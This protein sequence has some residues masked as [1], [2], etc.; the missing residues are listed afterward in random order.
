AA[1]GPAESVDWQTDVDQSRSYY[2]GQ[3]VTHSIFGS[4]VV[5][6][7]EGAGD[8]MLVTVD[9]TESGRKHINPRF[10]PLVPL[11]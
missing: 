7:V 1:N 2:Q 11:D 10:A 8:D 3:V 9:F 5:A 6:R 4:G